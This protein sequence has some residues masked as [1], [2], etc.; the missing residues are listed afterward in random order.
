MVQTGKFFIVSG[1]VLAALGALLLAAG[2]SGWVGRLPGDIV[3]QRRNFT[4]YFPVMT[5]IALSVI[6][7]LV[8]WFSGKR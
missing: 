6:L 8:F 5:G 3:V 7:T 2:T 1:M 4:F